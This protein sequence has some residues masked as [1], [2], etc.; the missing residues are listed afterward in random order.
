MVRAAGPPEGVAA[1]A[2]AHEAVE[3]LRI[4]PWAELLGAA[5]KVGDR[6]NFDWA[7][8][9]QNPFWTVKVQIRRFAVETW[10]DQLNRQDFGPTYGLRLTYDLSSLVLGKG[11]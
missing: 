5:A 6:G 10:N 9:E 8:I 3:Q 4:D 7:Q 1:E 11:P 2:L